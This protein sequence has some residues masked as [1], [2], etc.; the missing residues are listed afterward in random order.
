MS[1]QMNVSAFAETMLASIHPARGR[2]GMGWSIERERVDAVLAGEY[3]VVRELGR[4]GMGVVFLARDLVLQRLVAIK[5]L[6]HEFA[7][8]EEWRERFRREARIK[9]RLQHGSIVAVHSFSEAVDARAGN[10]L[11]LCY[12]VMRYVQG[13]S[14]AARM[15]R[16]GALDVGTTRQI[17]TDLAQALDYAHRDGIVHRD[18]KP[19]NVLLDRDTGRAMLTDFGVAYIRSLG[20]ADGTARLG[21]GPNVSVGTPA[22]MS[23]EQCTGEPDLDG[24]SDLYALGVLGYQMLSGALPFEAPTDTALAA[25]H[26]AVLPDPLQERAPNADATLVATIERCLEKQRERR[27][28]TGAELCAR[29]ATAPSGRF[30]LASFA[31]KVAAAA[32]VLG[33]LS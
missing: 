30:S 7:A 14:L 13:E 19:E 29:L 18:L 25:M 11:P 32:L 5:V 17:L 9:A 26:V 21:E 27:P 1:A 12:L 28:R 6:R 31:A 15:D 4:G 22:Y 16:D 24:R 3:Q 23:P 10:Q 33:V 2:E 20:P 8:S